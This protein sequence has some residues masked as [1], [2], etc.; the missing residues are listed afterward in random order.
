MPVILAQ[1]ISSAMPFIKKWAWVPCVLIVATMTAAIIH[2]IGI[3]D[4]KRAEREAQQKAV[5]LAK[6]DVDKAQSEI[7]AV[8]NVAASENAKVITRYVTVKDKESQVS[9]LN[10]P[11]GGADIISLLNQ[12]GDSPVSKSA[13]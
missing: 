8:S 5:D 10:Q 13:K 12:A 6:K 11:C 9:G 1:I 3:S 4:G 2:H 7:D